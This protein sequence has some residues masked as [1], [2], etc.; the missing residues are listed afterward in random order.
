MS[1]DLLVQMAYSERFSNSCPSVESVSFH[2][3]CLGLDGMCSIDNASPKILF[4]QRIF[5]LIFISR[6]QQVFCLSPP[7]LMHIWCQIA[8]LWVLFERSICSFKLQ[9]QSPI[10]V[11]SKIWTSIVPFS[12]V[13]KELHCLVRPLATCVQMI[14]CF[15]WLTVFSP[16][17]IPSG[18]SKPVG[19]FHTL[20][21]QFLWACQAGTPSLLVSPPCMPHSFLRLLLPI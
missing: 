11:T 4:E 1:H 16:T 20:W 10:E 6:I 8:P 19:I 5:P 13:T 15:L 12:D 7:L 3:S 21:K 2:Q 14:S 18:A 9:P 17:L